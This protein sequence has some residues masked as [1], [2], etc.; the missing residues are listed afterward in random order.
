MNDIHRD[1]NDKLKNRPT[2]LG[3]ENNDGVQLI[4][5]LGKQ[6]KKI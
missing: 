2:E 4:K 3:K 6:E 1:V 5:T